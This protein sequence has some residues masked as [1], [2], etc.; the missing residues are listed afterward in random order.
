MPDTPS[1]C[2]S[3][4]RDLFN[5]FGFQWWWLSPHVESG[6]SP[7]L[8][9]EQLS[10]DAGASAAG[11]AVGEGSAPNAGAGA[12]RAPGRSFPP[13]STLCAHHTEWRLRT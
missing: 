3:A 11:D 7:T 1:V 2:P 13:S 8:R 5:P 12:E 4:A 10:H 9:T 6:V